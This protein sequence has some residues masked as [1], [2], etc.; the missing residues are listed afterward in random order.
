[1]DL[2]ITITN[3]MNKTVSL[4]ANYVFLEK[5]WFVKCGKL[6][7]YEEEYERTFSNGSTSSF[8]VASS[9]MKSKFVQFPLILPDPFAVILSNLAFHKF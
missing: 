8:Q 3:S 2:V 9:Y 5:D 6:Y 1:M 4:V 7:Q